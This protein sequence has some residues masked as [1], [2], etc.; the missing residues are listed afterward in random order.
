MTGW[1]N[2][3]YPRIFE[4]LTEQNKTAADMARG[5]GVSKGNI[6]TW[7]SG[8]SAPS[9]AALVA[10]ANYLNTTVKYITG[11]TDIKEKPVADDE[12]SQNNVKFIGRNGT[13]IYKRVSPEFIKI[14]ES[15]PDT[16]ED[17]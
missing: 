14:L 3:K 13:V 12:L 17:L 15:I 1:D 8:A 4:L 5:I 10:I 7:K 16:D 9:N 6:T 2:C 11:E